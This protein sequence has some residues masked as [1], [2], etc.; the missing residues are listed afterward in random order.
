[1]G[2]PGALPS[3]KATQLQ[4]NL[5]RAGTGGEVIAFEVGARWPPLSGFHAF[6]FPPGAVRRFR[7]LNNCDV[8]HS[9][10]HRDTTTVIDNSENT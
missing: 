3:R 7:R 6:S 10:K 9:G 5:R 2:A 8:Q 1:M 4:K